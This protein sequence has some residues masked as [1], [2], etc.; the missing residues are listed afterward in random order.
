MASFQDIIVRVSYDTEKAERQARSLTGEL[1]KLEAGVSKTSKS[2]TD[3]AKK[4][5][6]AIDGANKS[7]STFG[8]SVKAFVA[9]SIITQGFSK[10]TQIVEEFAKNVFNATKEIESLRKE[11]TF[12]TDE[13][14][15]GAAFEELKSFALQN[16]I[17]NLKTAVTQTKD[18]LVKGF[19]VRESIDLV[20]AF[21]DITAGNIDQL[22]S[23][24]YVLGEIKLKNKITQQEIAQFATGGVNIVELAAKLPE[25]QG[26][27]LRQVK[28]LLT[29][30]ADAA[31]LVNRAII[32]STQEGGKFFGRSA[33]AA[34]TLNGQLLALEDAVFNLY[35]TIGDNASPA[36]T[37]FVA[38]LVQAVNAA[39]DIAKELSND[40]E[41]IA[42]SHSI[43]ELAGN[44]EFLA[45]GIVEVVKTVGTFSFNAINLS[46]KALNSTF[47]VNPIFIAGKKLYEEQK[48]QQAE[49]AK[50]DKE[51]ADVLR[52]LKI[53]E[54]AEQGA[55]VLNGAK[56]SG[57]FLQ[58]QKARLSASLLKVTLTDLDKFK[59]Q[60]TEKDIKIV[61]KLIG[62]DAKKIEKNSEL[63]DKELK[64]LKKDADNAKK[65]AERIQKFKQDSLDK[66]QEYGDRLLAIITENYRDI[67][68]LRKGEGTQL[69]KDL[70]EISN[71]RAKELEEVI[72]MESDLLKRQ[73]EIRK[74]LKGNIPKSLLDE[75]EKTGQRLSTIR[76]QIA[77]IAKLS[78]EKAYRE[79]YDRIANIVKEGEKNI[80]DLRAENIAKGLELTQEGA[81]RELRIENDRYKV[82]LVDIQEQYDTILSEQEAAF[83]EQGESLE[84]FSLFAVELERERAS[85]L[86]NARIEHLN[87]LSR[88]QEAAARK[89]LDRLRSEFEI[90]QTDNDTRLK[91]EISATEEFYDNKIFGAYISEQKITEIK[92]K[93]NEERIRLEIDAKQ[94][95]LQ[96]LGTES[97]GATPERAAEIEKQT[98]DIRNSI[99]GLNSE[100]DASADEAENREREKW[101]KI[102]QIAQQ[103][104]EQ[105][106]NVLEAINQKTID[107][108][109]R[110]IAGQEQRIK[111]AAEIAEN[112]NAELLQLEQNRLDELTQKRE[113]AAERQIA[114]NRAAQISAQLL[115]VAEVVAQTAGTPGGIFLIPLA[116][117]G[118]L[119]SLAAG[120]SAA[121][122]Y[123]EGTAFLDKE[124]KYPKGKDMI[125]A[126][127][128]KRPIRLNG[129]EAIIPT[130]TNEAY[131][132]AVEG[133]LY[134]K[135]PAPI[136]NAFFA[137]ELFHGATVATGVEQKR[138]SNDG[139]SKE[140]VNAV[141]RL[142]KAYES[143]D[144][145]P[146]VSVFVDT[147]EARK[148]ELKRERYRHN[149]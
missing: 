34:K 79:Q 77:D 121:E 109:D 3:G 80:L 82:A 30:S 62:L 128:G 108:L 104:T 144:G 65:E 84:A 97:V 44:F 45:A 31:N 123:Y 52:L 122:G 134:K 68:V 26:K 125:P 87:N 131:K 74:E 36:L 135:I 18:L 32:Q 73:E 148:R 60:L 23:L 76:G 91:Y 27:S 25:F 35:S 69:E 139:S 113:Q 12:F 107:S 130:S 2:I 7:I 20:K 17:A 58:V 54:I 127:V 95:E 59:S 9:G 38:Q 98:S 136:A 24:S 66:E 100:L 124:G 16:P 75:F 94:K 19:G 37:E 132:T 42:F 90:R 13:I 102:I 101:G 146:N 1:G 43:A 29:E 142:T 115:A 8:N 147:V 110:Q 5:Q 40:E 88:I 96:L 61:E 51:R 116:I 6:T 15:G 106:F 81:G 114:I 140:L 117:L 33:S 49:L 39:K 118:L 28:T 143:K 78:N 103:A 133:I 56:D 137:G 63:S 138:N 149:R 14:T 48:K 47:S 141:K 112:G 64:K 22:N 71:K 92:R 10:G 4:Q 11:L 50:G 46:L 119:G 72:G 57:E 83:K 21:T 99:A 111:R 86:E 85:A 55:P 70:L 129:G 145:S 53:Q 120:L 41:I 89:E 105:L 93:A 126:V 67:E